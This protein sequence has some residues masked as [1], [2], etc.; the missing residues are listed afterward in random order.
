M[1]KSK[2]KAALPNAKRLFGKNI[3]F[4]TFGIGPECPTKGDTKGTKGFQFFPLK[5]GALVKTEAK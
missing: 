1:V 3:Q 5:D 4:N 2:L